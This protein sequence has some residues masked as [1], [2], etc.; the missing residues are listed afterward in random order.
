MPRLNRIRSAYNNLSI[1]H[2]MLLLLSVLMIGCFVFYQLVL[3]YVFRIYDRQI[4]EKSSQV[5]GTSS[6]AIENRLREVEGLSFRVLAD[7]VIQQALGKLS[8]SPTSYEQNVLRKRVADQ[9]I[10]YAGSEKDVYSI[11]L[12]DTRGIPI[13]AGNREGITAGMQLDLVALAERTDGAHAWKVTADKRAAL[14]SVRKIRS[15][16]TQNLT[17]DN[18][19]TLIIRTRIDRIIED[20]MDTGPGQARLI[21]TDGKDIIYPLADDMPLTAAEAARTAAQGKPYGVE[22][23]AGGEYFT[24]LMASKN[25]GWTYLYVTPFDE[26]FRQLTAVKR[27]VLASFVA[28]FLAALL[29]GAMLSSSINRP[30]LLLLRKMRQIEKGQLDRLEEQSLG[31]VPELSHHEAG[32]LHR[33]FTMMLQRIRELIDENYA[34]QL[35]IREAELKALQAQINPHFLYNTLES[36]N[37]QAKMN[38]QRSISE[39]VEAL[40]HLMRSSISGT[41]DLLPLE[42]EL[43]L[44]R[45]YV[46]IQAIRYEERLDFRLEAEEEA[47]PALLPKLTLQ[48]LV[49]NAVHYALEPMIEPCVITVSASTSGGRLRLAVSDTGPGMPPEFVERLRRGEVRTR[50]QGIGLANIAER[51]RLTYGGD[52]S[53]EIESAEGKG[54]TVRLDMPYTEEREE[55]SHAKRAAGR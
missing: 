5:L 4:Y 49:E 28:I 55:T 7:P 39:M 46:T 54:T 48:P 14:L 11:L 43:E 9:L 33:T 26:M 44:V 27:I 19:G 21:L 15:F 40:G 52:A 50:G 13:S 42:Q 32:I 22:S 24:A 6:I 30:M 23:Y 1:H 38:G 3:G 25:M 10:S 31:A 8:G 20:Q 2:K 17:F 51:L 45:S 18:L 41:E 53:L 47:L 34:K 16:T 29:L 35:T 37:W 36:I 12:I